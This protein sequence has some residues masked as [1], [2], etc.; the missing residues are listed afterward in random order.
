MTTKLEKPSA[1]PT[2]T[3][4]TAKNHSNSRQESGYGYKEETFEFEPPPEAPVF[5]P[6]EEE[7][8][9]PLEYI[10]KI[11]KYAEGSGICKIKPPPNWQPPFAVDV[12]KLRFTPRIQRLN[13]LEVF[14]STI[15]SDSKFTIL[16]IPGENAGQVEF[17]RSN[18]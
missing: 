6:T 17:S 4:G 10:N 13:E 12:D 16:S 2:K 1:S 14:L 5:H 15:G 8:N 9:D 18:R 3:Y 7:F 11:R